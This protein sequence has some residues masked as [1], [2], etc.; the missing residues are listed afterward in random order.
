MTNEIKKILSQNLG[1]EDSKKYIT[2]FEFYNYTFNKSS[3][4]IKNIK[5]FH[6]IDY[7]DFTIGKKLCY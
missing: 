3:I 5:E 2:D 6:H 4:N 7:L 1:K